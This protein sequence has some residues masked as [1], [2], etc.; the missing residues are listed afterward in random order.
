MNDIIKEYEEERA[1][2]NYYS[3]IK[4]HKNYKENVKL[5]VNHHHQH[6]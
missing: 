6:R 4:N 3:V 1:K 2:I 5:V